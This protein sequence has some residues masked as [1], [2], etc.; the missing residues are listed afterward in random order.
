MSTELEPN[1]GV[2]IDFVLHCDGASRG[3]PGPSGA[4]A[5]LYD[6]AG[7]EVAS[8][9]RRLDDGT[10]NEAEYEAIALGVERALARGVRRIAIRA[11]SEVVVKQLNGVYKV[12]EPRLCPRHARVRELLA[13]FDR[14]EVGWIPRERNARADAL[15]NEAID[16]SDS[17]ESAP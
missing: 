3:N 2:E 4:G 1:A 15:A 11:D 14:Y 10:N 13:G 16:A 7:N 17:S 6:A 8:F 5:V 12:R 9:R